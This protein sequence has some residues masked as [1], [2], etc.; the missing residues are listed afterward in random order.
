LDQY[1]FGKR[2]TLLGQQRLFAMQAREA[3]YDQRPEIKNEMATITQSIMRFAF[4][5]KEIKAKVAAQMETIQREQGNSMTPADLQQFLVKKS[6]ELEK[7]LRNQL[8]TRLKSQYDFS[9]HTDQFSAALAR[10][11]EKKSAS[12]AA[13]KATAKP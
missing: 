11:A 4:Y 10:A 8:E 3:K 13:A 12:K 7:D 2:L 1:E 6:S 9:F 5:Q